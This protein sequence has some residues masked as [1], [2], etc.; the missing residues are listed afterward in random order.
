VHDLK[1]AKDVLFDKI[2]SYD[3]RIESFIF[4]V[5]EPTAPSAK[6]L[7]LK[8]EYTTQYEPFLFHKYARLSSDLFE[9]V[10]ELSSKHDDC[11]P[12]IG[13]IS[14]YVGDS[15]LRTLLNNLFSDEVPRYLMLCFRIDALNETLNDVLKFSI[16]LVG[17]YLTFCIREI[18]ELK[19]FDEA[20]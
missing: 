13:N 17:L 2:L 10:K 12:I 5:A 18:I 7:R 8:K 15:F 19:A 20:R 1:S 14:L 4:D 16:K 3:V 9:K 11:D 6:T